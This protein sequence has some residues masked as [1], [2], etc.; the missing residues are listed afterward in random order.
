MVKALS[1]MGGNVIAQIGNRLDPFGLTT[2]AV[3]KANQ[4][5]AHVVVTVDCG[6][7]AFEAAER[8]GELGMDLIITD[9]H[10][11]SPDG[12]LPHCVACVNPNRQDS[13]YPFPGLAGVGV[14]LKLALA[15]AERMGCSPD[16]VLNQLV[17]YV[18][19]GTVAD[20]VPML[21][22]NRILTWL[23]CERMMRTDKP[24]IDQ[25]IRTSGA[26]RIDSTS[27]GF[28]LAPRINAA[29]R[30]FEP[31][32]A[33]ELLLESESGKARLLA[34]R[35]DAMNAERKELQVRIV[36]QIRSDLPDD[37]SDVHA[38]VLSSN[39][40]HVGING[41]VCTSLANDLGK[42]TFIST[43]DE[44]AVAKGSCRG[45]PGF[46]VLDAL[47]HVG[48]LLEGFGGH[49]AAAGYTIQSRHLP[50]LAERLNEYAREVLE[51][52]E[53]PSLEIDARMTHSEISM[54]TYHAIC[55]LAP[56]GK[57]N[58]EPI[59]LTERLRLEHSTRFGKEDAHLRLALSDS[60]GRRLDAI[61]WRNGH[62]IEQFPFGAH[63]DVVHKLCVDEY[64]NNHNLMLTVEDMRLAT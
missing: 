40:F 48:D 55:E 13:E 46:D 41:L 1:K 14:A 61:F 60:Q 31:Q 56:F 33:L 43:I 4:Q 21:G 44:N 53:Q 27:I 19:I 63:L 24:G 50:A 29:D 57:D 2:Q 52:Q 47:R 38:I 10:Q 16:C 51:H 35:L 34:D 45:I 6:M 28:R 25:L 17:E 54:E 37:L 59:F 23:G 49:P 15:L 26:G 11:P 18:A 42:P 22:E 64:R 3:R 32:I 39:E 62:S 58:P 5:H 30:L 12:R 36:T 8:A 9:H 7:K 20:V